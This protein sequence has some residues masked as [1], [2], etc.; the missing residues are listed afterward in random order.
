[1]FQ[2]KYLHQITK[3]SSF[4]SNESL[5]NDLSIE[6]VQNETKSYYKR[7]NANIK[8]IEE[9]EYPNYPTPIL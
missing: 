1:M 3:A 7:F 6:I 2:S 8:T 5:H 9:L 4:V